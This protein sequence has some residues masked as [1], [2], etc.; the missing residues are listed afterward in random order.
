LVPELPADPSH[1]PA[2]LGALG[3]FDR[4]TIT[5]ADTK[6]AAS[7]AANATRRRLSSTLSFE[8]FLRSLE[9]EV[10]IEAVDETTL[11]RAAQLCQRTNQFNLTT[12]R[13]TLA[14]LEAMLA[15]GEH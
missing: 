8:D 5:E 11:A 1:R 6:R 14:D 13:H 9:Q 4:V 12:R 10:T 7:Y 15:G 3:V 2:F